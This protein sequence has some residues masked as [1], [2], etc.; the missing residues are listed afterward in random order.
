MILSL[1]TM[2]AHT[3]GADTSSVVLFDQGHGQK[4]LPGDNGPLQLSL[5]AETLADRGLKIVSNTSIF[6][7][8]ALSKGNILVISGAF[9]QITPTEVEV[10]F[11]FIEQGGKLVVMLHIG[12]SVADLLHRLNV[13]FSNGAIREQQDIIGNETL[14]FHVTRFEN[15]LLTKDLTRFSLYG[16]W[17]LM[18]TSDRAEIIASTSPEA[19]IDLDGDR[20]LTEEDAIQSFG[21]VVT[22][23]VGKGEFV[24]FGD[25]AIFQ[26]R[27][28]DE[29]NRILA[30]NLAN[31]LM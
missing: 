9:S 19:W 28:L 1:L 6:T 27:F 14:N 8:E 5:F 10:I 15:H 24:I 26:N 13:D 3:Y 2:T 18:N 29:D 16:G 21:V 31:W 22:G 23:K 20:K 12:P 4:F 7:E 17:A 30:R 11:K 25:D